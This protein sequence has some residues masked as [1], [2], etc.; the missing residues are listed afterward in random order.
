MQPSTD[1]VREVTI[2]DRKDVEELQQGCKKFMRRQALS[3]VMGVYDPLGLISPVVLPGKLL[4][5]QLY[6]GDNTVGWDIDIPA[7]EKSLWAE[8]FTVLLEQVEVVFSRSTCPAGAT[9]SPQ[10]A[11]FCDSSSQAT[12][13]VV[14]IVWTSKTG[15]SSRVL[16]GKCRVAPA[17]GMTIPRGEMQ[18]LVVLHCLLL[19]AVEAFPMR[20]ASVSAYTDSL[21]NIRALAKT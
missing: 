4:L 20:C 3:L 9:G 18:S 15:P 21:C 19:V 2:F 11:G 12:C 10:M 13:A 7:S 16:L 14:Y 1:V 5:L 17:L 6:A 8:W